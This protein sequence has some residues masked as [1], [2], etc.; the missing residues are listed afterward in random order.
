MLYILKSLTVFLLLIF[1][2]HIELSAQVAS[3][4][5][6][7]LLMLEEQ[8]LADTLSI[9]QRTEIEMQK[10]ELYVNKKDWESAEVI[11]K[12]I[13]LTMLSD[14]ERINFEELILYTYLQNGQNHLASSRLKTHEP[15]N[16]DT[17]LILLRSIVLLENYNWSGF[18][19]EM[20][21]IDTS[22]YVKAKEIGEIDEFDDEVIA[23]TLPGYYLSTRNYD[24]FISTIGLRII[25]PLIFVTSIVAGL[26]VTGILIGGYLAY[27]IYGTRKE[28][29]DQAAHK[30]SL[31][32][33]DKKK[34]AGYN[35]L[36]SIK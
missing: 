27:R 4:N 31:Q 18:A 34:L 33:S 2:I 10:F 12:R 32:I 16:S 9:K 17:N 28:V 22:L 20:L 35:L 8:L 6:S 3:S 13:D 11:S 14:K 26:P 19:E 30:R 29:I 36:K 21:R 25:P 15:L 23:L 5:S 7:L 24:K 1:N